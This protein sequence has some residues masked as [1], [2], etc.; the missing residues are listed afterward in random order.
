MAFWR[1]TAPPQT[2]PHWEGENP[3]PRPHPLVAPS[4]GNFCVRPWWQSHTWRHTWY[5]LV[6]RFSKIVTVKR[7]PCKT[8]LQLL[9]GFR[10]TVTIFGISGVCALLSAILISHCLENRIRKKE[11]AGGFFFATGGTAIA[12][13]HYVLISAFLSQPSGIPACWWST[14][15]V[16]PAPL[17]LQQALLSPFKNVMA[18]T[19]PWLNI[20]H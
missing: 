16:T 3:L 13:L 11:V 19:L 5:V 20:G 17:H 9:H 14:G 2:P 7:N 15:T 18:L 6:K 4:N 8:V 10:L 1:G 12:A